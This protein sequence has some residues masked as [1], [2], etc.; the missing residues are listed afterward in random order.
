VKKAPTDTDTAVKKQEKM[1]AGRMTMEE[2]KV[3]SVFAM[4]GCYSVLSI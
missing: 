4:A 3:M 2:E 1:T